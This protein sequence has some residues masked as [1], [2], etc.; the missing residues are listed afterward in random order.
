MVNLAASVS[1]NWV[2]WLPGH[3]SCAACHDRNLLHQASSSVN[4]A[5][6][7]SACKQ[8]DHHEWLPDDDL[9]VVDARASAGAASWKR[10]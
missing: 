4:V 9:S 3:A 10:N 6:F 2:W 1:R 7:A 8:Q 5:A